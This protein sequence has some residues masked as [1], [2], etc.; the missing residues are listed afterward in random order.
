MP[1]A[2][3]GSGH[4]LWQM[5]EDFAASWALLHDTYLTGWLI[6]GLL[7]LCGVLVVARDQ[8]FLG[9]AVAQSSTLGV[10]CGLLVFTWLGE[11]GHHHGATHDDPL[12]LAREA[13]LAAMAVL[14]SVL[15]TLITAQPAKAGRDSQQAVTGWV[16]LIAA[17]LSVLA[18]A[19][20]PHG[21]G[22]IHR[23]SF[24]SI[25]GATSTDVALYA[26]L[27]ALSAAAVALLRRR[28]L[29]FV[30]DPELA[31][32]VGMRVRLWTAA[33]FLWIGLVIGLAIRSGGTLYTF[34]CLV[35]PALVAKNLCREVRPMLVVAPVV[36]VLGAVAAFVLANHFDFPPAQMAVGL[37]ALLLVPAWVVRA[38]RG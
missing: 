9:A 6:A 38:R 5:L 1:G 15:A 22:E 33:T 27:L 23:L 28:L 31:R 21:M 34:G 10:V 37:L 2:G 13:V 14:F 8:I 4:G 30:V 12:P 35:L 3:N 32:A 11:A 24:S 20:D 36:G 26:V 29:L 18:M 19:H 25:I 16:F 7:G 17:G